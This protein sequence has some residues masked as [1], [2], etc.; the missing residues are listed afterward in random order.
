[1]ATNDAEYMRQW[2]AANREKDRER[3]RRSHAK[4]REKELKQNA[5]WRKNNP[6]YAFQKNLQKYGLTVEDYTQMYN[7]QDWVCALC[8]DRPTV[9][10]DHCHTTGKVRGLLCR[11]C[12]TG[13]G[14][15]SDSVE[16]LK[17]A[18]NY[19]TLRK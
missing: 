14:H 19:L 18:I 9:V 6:D 5:E 4:H 7:D 17:K 8:F 12:N 13:I 2:R 11:Q 3:S 10:V 16:M 1:M 15:L